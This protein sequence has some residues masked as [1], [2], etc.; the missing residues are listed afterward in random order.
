MYMLKTLTLFSHLS[1]HSLRAIA[2]LE[3][4]VERDYTPKK[5]VGNLH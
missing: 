1:D 3:L 5:D 4:D 2:K